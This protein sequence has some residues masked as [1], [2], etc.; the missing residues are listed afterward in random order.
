MGEQDLVV[1][2]GE[3]RRERGEREREDGVGFTAT[4]SAAGDGAGGL[5]VCGRRRGV[6]LRDEQEGVV[7]LAI[8]EQLQELV[9]RCARSCRGEAETEGQKSEP[10]HGALPPRCEKARTPIA[11]ARSHEASSFHGSPRRSLTAS[12]A[13]LKHGSLTATTPSYGKSEEAAASLAMQV[14]SSCPGSSRSVVCP[15][16]DPR[17]RPANSTLISG[18]Q[19]RG[20]EKGEHRANGT[21]RSRESVEARRL[22]RRLEHQ[23]LPRT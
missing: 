20:R 2:G 19:F 8:G 7:T 5:F 6:D 4:G 1:V 14:D 18:L 12:A 22:S 3:A 21:G 23:L 10:F 9:E 15:R 13:P 16:R 11:S 17:Q